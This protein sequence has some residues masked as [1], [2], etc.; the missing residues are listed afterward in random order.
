MYRYFQSLLKT[1][2]DYEK[3]VL[4][5]CS[6]DSEAEAIVRGSFFRKLPRIFFS[7]TRA[8]DRYNRI[9]QKLADLNY[10]LRAALGIYRATLS[11]LIVGIFCQTQFTKEIGCET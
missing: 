2:I 10:S 7:V 5:Y 4:N 1:L 9:M 11:Q 6:G 3:S 8:Y